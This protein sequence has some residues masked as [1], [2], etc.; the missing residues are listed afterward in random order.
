MTISAADPQ[1]RAHSGEQRS[2]HSGRSN[3]EM[4]FS[5][6]PGCSLHSTGLEYHLSVEA[7]FHALGASLKEL[8]DWNCCSAA[9]A[10]SLN[11]ALALVIPGRNLAIAQQ[12]GLEVVMPCTG[13]FIRHKTTE[14]E[15]LHNPEAKA[16]IEE[17]AG[18][19]YSGAVK[20]RPVLDII[21]N[22]IGLEKA[23]SL[24]RMPLKGLKVVP[25]YGCLLVR[26]NRV[27]QFEN[28]ENPTLLPRLLKLLGAEVQDWSYATDCCGGDLGLVKAGVTNKLV[29]NLVKHAREAG[30][31]A[32]VTMCP[33]CQ[34]NLE[35]R[36]T[37][38]AERMPMFYFTELMG[39]AFGLEETKS[40]WGK[41]LINPAGI[42]QSAGL[43]GKG[44]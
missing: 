3:P 38:L 41:H 1:T 44:K 10:Y 34:V 30:A 36:Q 12:A 42:L 35:M 18:F 9:S 15:L 37:G 2:E 27:T 40:W 11:H 13:C 23:R 25:Y 39:L 29:T 17:A 20:I 28:P 4:E 14:Y 31:A 22:Q 7:V 19:Q 26:P 5:Y 16:L 43:V 6:Y 33:L 21:A 8:D 24:V 32:M